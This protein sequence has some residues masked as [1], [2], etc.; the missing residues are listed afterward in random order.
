MNARLVERVARELLIIQKVQAFIED[1][2]LQQAA[3]A[4]WFFEQGTDSQKQQ[5]VIPSAIARW[6]K[7]E[8]E[9]VLEIVYCL[10]EEINYHQALK[11]LKEA[12]HDI[13]E[14]VE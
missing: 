10:L 8:P 2:E 6:A 13:E 12:V 1:P 3:L 11:Y 5:A 4:K 9:I 7:Y 14:D